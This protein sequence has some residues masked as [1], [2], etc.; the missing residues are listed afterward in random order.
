MSAYFCPTCGKVH[1]YPPRSQAEPYHV[2]WQ[3]MAVDGAKDV[4]ETILGVAVLL[5]FFI[6]IPW[7]AWM[8]FG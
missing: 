1:Q 2:T 5:T 3:Q 6:G 8:V 7:L 4:A